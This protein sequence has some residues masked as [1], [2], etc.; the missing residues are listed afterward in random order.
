M[1]QQTPG[2]LYDNT[3]K[4]KSKNIVCQIRQEKISIN[5]NR[6]DFQMMYF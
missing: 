6:T 3:N 1:N 4:R 5:E 2:K